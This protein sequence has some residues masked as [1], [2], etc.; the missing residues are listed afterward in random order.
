MKHTEAPW[1]AQDDGTIVG[2]ID[3]PDDGRLHYETVCQVEH[4]RDVAIITAAP[5]MLT[6]LAEAVGLLMGCADAMVQAGLH[7]SAITLYDKSTALLKLMIR[8]GG[9]KSDPVPDPVHL[10][11]EAL[12]KAKGET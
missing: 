7:R 8:A 3:G 5:E 4:T 9:G 10:T 6:G 11:I 12:R 2:A 1:Q